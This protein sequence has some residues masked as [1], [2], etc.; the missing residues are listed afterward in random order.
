M[1]ANPGYT[2]SKWM[3]YCVSRKRFSL[4]TYKIWKHSQ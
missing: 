2:I 1:V 3:P 4:I